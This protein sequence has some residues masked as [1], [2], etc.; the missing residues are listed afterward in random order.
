MGN[1]RKI[2][3]G[4]NLMYVGNIIIIAAALC[5][6]LA[7]LMPFLVILTSLAIIVGG[8]VC[9][10][11]LV[12]LRNEHGDYMNALIACV[13]GIVFNLFSRGDSAFANFMSIANTICTLLEVYFVIRGTNSF[14]RER[15]CLMEVAMGDKAWRWQLIS[16]VAGVAAAILVAVMVFVAPGMIIVLVLGSLVVSIAALVFYLSY[17]KAGAGALS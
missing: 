10:V 17:L 1:T 4:L 15:G 7:M 8:V 11:G 9:L 13:L 12:K 2:S 14:L 5:T 3:E 16:A 6:L